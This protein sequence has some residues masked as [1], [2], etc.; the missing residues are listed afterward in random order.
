MHND[1]PSRLPTL[2]AAVDRTFDDA[3]FRRLV[4]DVP[5][6]AIFLIDPDGYVRTWNTG[7]ARLKGYAA[8][9]IIG[10]HFSVFYPQDAIDRGWPAHELHVARETGRFEDEGW[11]LRKDGTRFWANVVLTR[12]LDDD[13]SVL[14]F[15][16]ITRD[17]SARREHEELLR[18]S[19][20]RFRLMVEGVRD[21]AIF[22]LDP[23]GHVASWNAGAQ[24]A[25]GYAAD[26][27]IGQ[28]FSLFYPPEVVES[29]WPARELEI[30]MAEGRCEDEG[31][32]VRKDG[33]RF[34]ASVVITTLY[35]DHG[36]HIGFAKITRDLSDKRR[37]S[38][39][40]DEGRRVTTFL[41]MLGH[42][43]R[44]PLAPISNA[45]SIM[46]LE[47]MQSERLRMCRDVISRQLQ[48]ITRL[49]DDLL[50]VGRITAGKI[51]LQREPVELGA[52]LEEA[53]EAIEPYSRSR[54]HALVF[55]RE[56]PA[57][58]VGDRARLLQIVSNLLTNAAKFTGRGGRIVATLRCTAGHAELSV[59]D[60][61]PG[62]PASRLRDIFNL[63]VQGDQDPARTQ[64]GLGLGLSLVQQLTTL[65]GG[66][67]SAYSA[68]EGKGAEF[69]VRF[70]LVS[71]PSASSDE[72]V[73]WA[74]P[75]ARQVLVVDDNRDAADTMSMLLK[76]LGYRT[77]TAYDARSALEML[78]TS[79]PDVAI[80]DIGLP[81]MDGRKLA[82]AIRT[83]Y[84]DAVALIA[85]TGYG[86][87]QDRDATLD[88]GFRDHLTKPLSS[89]ALI[90]ALQRVFE[91][92][93]GGA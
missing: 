90:A 4:E 64:G 67:V 74:T 87:E 72:T 27:I 20:E 1:R 7:A 63:F 60:N 18:R 70:P 91:D 48:Q 5:D 47:P 42:E 11:R 36:R 59:A 29:G 44:N 39:L 25:K 77:R 37:V 32:R 46:Q 41:A 38:A 21:Y 34:W 2:T 58:I 81:D 71:A 92:D 45:V 31:W 73:D 86:Q 50:D 80:L 69:I 85:L 55:N 30:A 6:Y 26:E 9:E 88:A 49:V 51:H 8:D 14:G 13:G 76:A 35:D 19:E 93:L 65:M 78:Q 33:T 12:I 22:M 43:L 17:L 75:L 53:V 54:A 62:I 3:I 10:R 79:R 82:R 28:H 52:V 61:G 83:Q 15:S 24:Q 23:D 40:E 57:W 68:G 84:G 89:D 56:G 66:E 16:K